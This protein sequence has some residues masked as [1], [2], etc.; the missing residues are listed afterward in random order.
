MADEQSNI[1]T[2]KASDR[3]RSPD[4]LDEYVRV[5]NPSVWIV[6][7]ACAMLSGFSHGAS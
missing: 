2:K 3:L 6:L 1:F 7:A 4:D 5:T